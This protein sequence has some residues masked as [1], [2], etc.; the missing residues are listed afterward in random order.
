MESAKNNLQL[1]DTSSEVSNQEKTFLIHGTDKIPIYAE[2]TSRYSLSFR[3]LGRWR[4]NHSDEPVRLLIKDNGDSVELGPCRILSDTHLNRC[5]GRLVFMHDLY[6]FGHLLGKNK[7]LKLQTPFSDLPHVMARKNGIRS[8]FKE[9]TA[10]LTYD[11]SVYKN[12]FDG[13]DSQY[14]EDQEDEEVRKCVQRAIINSEG[15][16]FKRFLDDKLDELRHIVVD[17]SRTEHQHHGFY[18]RKQLWSFILCSA[19]IARTNL[20]P[21]GYAGDSEIMRMIYLNDYLGNSTFSKLMHKHAVEHPAAQSVRNRIELVAALHQKVRISSGVSPG[22][23][24]KVLSVGCGPALELQEVLKSPQD[25]ENYHFTLLDQDSLALSE[26]TALINEIEKKFNRKVSADYLGCSVRTMLFA[27]KLQQK[28]GQFHFIYSMGLFDYLATPVAKAVL[29]NLYRLLVPGG[30]MVIGNFHVMNPSTYYME[31]WC[32]WVL[33]QRT[34]EEF[35][36]LLK[37]NLSADVSI[38]FE[39]TG[40][41]MFLNIKKPAD[42]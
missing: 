12:L 39:N 13:V 34:E 23:K 5:G 10:D 8:S 22:E 19:L 11:L 35:K 29:K 14:G 27:R 9:Y 25:C 7:I 36:A 17:Y 6:D 28:M 3:Y 20:K 1:I 16:A 18:F 4:H 21:R 15:E 31:Y 40:S 33:Y 26:A 32:D 41:Q 2:N 24:M 30:K 37:D 42:T 38:F